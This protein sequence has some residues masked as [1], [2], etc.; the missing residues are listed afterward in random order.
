MINSQS[1]VDAPLW[2][3]LAAE[4]T[5]CLS[6]VSE[7]AGQEPRPD[8][9]DI[10]SHKCCLGTLYYSQSIHDKGRNPVRSRFVRAEILSGRCECA[11]EPCIA[12]GMRGHPQQAPDVF[13]PGATTTRKHTSWGIQGMHRFEACLGT[14]HKHV[15]E[16]PYRALLSC[17]SV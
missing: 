1:R 6:M 17:L 13:R 12:A 11:S 9:L 2:S 10:P 5:S 4:C 3:V 14:R 16:S 8:S 15:L 7:K